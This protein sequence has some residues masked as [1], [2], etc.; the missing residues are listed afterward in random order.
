MIRKINFPTVRLVDENSTWDQCL[1]SNK[2][3]PHRLLKL[4][5]WD[6]RISMKIPKYHKTNSF[7]LY[8]TCHSNF[9][10][11]KLEI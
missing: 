5:Q 3:I 1:S 11:T 2:I 6:I 10:L 4:T 9:Q 8:P 7:E